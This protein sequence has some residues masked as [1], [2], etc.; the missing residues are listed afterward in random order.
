MGTLSNEIVIARLTEKFGDKL[1]DIEEPYGL[2]TLT[3]DK[4]NIIPLISYMYDDEQLKFRF[5]TTLCGMHYQFPVQ[6]LGVF[7]HLHNLEDNVRI[8]IKIFFAVDDEHV[9]TLTNIFLAANWMERETFDY[10]GILFDGHPNLV[11]ILNTDDFEG[12][13]MRKEFP[14]EDQTREDKSDKMFGRV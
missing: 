2:L 10:Y 5:L 13:P 6:K 12:F 11:R 4:D 14:L 3:T 8:R 7:Y 1:R 9:P